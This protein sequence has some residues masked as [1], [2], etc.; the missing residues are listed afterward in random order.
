MAVR[1]DLDTAASAAMWNIVYCWRSQL[2]GN[3]L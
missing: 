3:T 2:E 1:F